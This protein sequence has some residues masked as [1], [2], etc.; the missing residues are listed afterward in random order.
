LIRKSARPPRRHWAK[1]ASN[2]SCREIAITVFRGIPSHQRLPRVSLFVTLAC[3]LSVEKPPRPD[4]PAP[5]AGDKKFN[6]RLLAPIILRNEP[7]G[8]YVEWL[9]HLSFIVSTWKVRAL[10]NK[11]TQ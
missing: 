3:P 4:F 1:S 11:L 7:I 5:D 9:F 8:E 2:S 6:S 10:R